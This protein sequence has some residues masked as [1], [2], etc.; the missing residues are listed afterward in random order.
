MLIVPPEADCDTRAWADLFVG[1]CV[2]YG[3]VDTGVAL[4]ELG[5]NFGLMHSSY[6]RYSGSQSIGFASCISPIPTFCEYGDL[7]DP[8]GWGLNQFHAFTK[9]K[10]GWIQPSDVVKVDGGNHDQTITLSADEQSWGVRDIEVP[11]DDGGGYSYQIEYRC[12]DERIS[13]VVIRLD[14]PNVKDAEGRDIEAFFSYLIPG[15]QGDR[16][17]ATTAGLTQPGQVYFD[18]THQLRI[19]LQAI[20]GSQAVV[21]VTVP[22]LLIVDVSYNGGKRLV[23]TGKNFGE[24]ANLLINGVNVSNAVDWLVRTEGRLKLRAPAPVL[25]F[26]AG[27]NTLQVMTSLGTLSNIFLVTL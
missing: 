17:D 1:N 20:N 25:G 6:I 21:R 13:G 24:A 15:Q 12:C 27:Q 3:N 18:A 14:K 9:V 26:R 11:L 19:E 4:H 16:F 2:L 10:L 22:P 8:M 7:G 5:H 23:V